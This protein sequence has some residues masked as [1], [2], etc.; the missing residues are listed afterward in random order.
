MRREHPQKKTSVWIRIL[1]GFILIFISANI[2][3]WIT[4]MTYVYKTLVYTYPDIDDLNI[5]ETRLIAA[6]EPRPWPESAGYNKKDLPPETISELEQT[7]TVEFVVVR[8]DSLCYE[9]YWDHYDKN[10]IS[11]SFSMAKSIVSLLI[12]MAAQDGKLSLDDPV[13]KYLPS[14][15]DGLD[16][17]LTIRDLM[18]MASGLD[19]DES[20]NSLFSYTTE[21]Y[22]GNNLRDLVGRLNVI[23]EPGKTFRYMS[24][25]SLILGMIIEKATGEK[26]AAYASGKLWTPVGAVHPAQWSLDHK[27]GDEK[28]Y[29]CFYSNARDFARIGQ[30]MLDSGNWQGRQLLSPDRV[31]EL[32][33][34]AGTKTPDGKPVDFYGLQWWLLNYKGTGVFY[35]RGILGQYIVVIPQKRLVFVRLGKKRGVKTPDNHYTDMI[36]YLD[37]VL[38]TF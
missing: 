37:G 35:A 26:L 7:E 27:G 3:I 34:P 33:T 13:M 10:T 2:A 30:L 19:W 5:F 20:Y 32:L 6:K 17:K 38:K 31:K 25:N 21:A 18:M 4:G 8:N 1:W 28:A 14:F 24:C 11:N 29:C 23:E 16:A 15:S 36:A 9:H 12:E 22:Y